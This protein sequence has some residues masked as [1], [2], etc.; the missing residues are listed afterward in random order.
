MP[1]CSIFK[2]NNSADRGVDVIEK[3]IAQQQQQKK[4][5]L[6]IIAC[7][8]CEEEV[9]TPHPV[10]QFT[11]VVFVEPCGRLMKLLSIECWGHQQ[12]GADGQ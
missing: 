5:K 12:E 4:Y 9:P 3:E 2:H 6:W 7:A 10:K 11:A 1:P 8:M